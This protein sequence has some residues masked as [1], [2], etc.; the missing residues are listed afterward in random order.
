MNFQM[1]K[2]CA[3]VEPHVTVKAQ[4]GLTDPPTWLKKIWTICVAT[5]PF[6]VVVSEVDHFGGEAVY[7]K[8]DSPGLVELHRS[9]VQAICPTSDEIVNFHEMD[10]FVPHLTLSQSMPGQGIADVGSVVESAKDKFKSPT[11]FICGSVKIYR[12]TSEF[13]Q[14]RVFKEYGLGFEC[15]H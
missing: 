3:L 10:G 13:G 14:Y 12:A 9:F 1:G 2:A 5:H 11:S 8:V 7:L 4:S 6:P 15:R